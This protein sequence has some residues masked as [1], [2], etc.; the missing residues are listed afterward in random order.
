MRVLMLVHVLVLVKL[1]PQ[2]R[3]LGQ[4]RAGRPWCRPPTPLRT[5]NQEAVVQ[6]LPKEVVMLWSKKERW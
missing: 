6:L 1:R 2:E 3:H 5:L 4:R